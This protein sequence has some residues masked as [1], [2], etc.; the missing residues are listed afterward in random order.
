MNLT[1]LDFDKQKMFTEK[2]HSGYSCYFARQK[3]VCKSTT[4][5]LVKRSCSWMVYI[6]RKLCGDSQQL[7]KL[8]AVS[9]MALPHV[10]LSLN[11]PTTDVNEGDWRLCLKWEILILLYIKNKTVVSSILIPAPKRQDCFT[12]KL[13]ATSDS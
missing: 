10:L 4:L 11:K 5:L 12:G 13:D 9:S 8:Q 1:Q 3:Y 2:E 7:D 6:T